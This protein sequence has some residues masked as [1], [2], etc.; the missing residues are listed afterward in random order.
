MPKYSYTVINQEGQKLTGTIEAD[1]EKAAQENLSK[2][3]FPILDITEISV[4]KL[5]ELSEQ[6]EKFEFQ[7]VDQNGKKVVGTIGASDKHA[8]FKRL[9]TEYHFAVEFLYQAAAS[10][11]AKEEEK[12]QGIVELYNEL[13]EEQSHMQAQQK[14]NEITENTEEKSQKV[15]KQVD[16]V[17]E[18]VSTLLSSF[19]DELKPDDKATIE[20]KSSRLTRL[21]TS[22]NIDYVKHLAEDLL[23]FMQNEEIYVPQE[24]ENKK[25]ELFRVDLKRVMNEIQREKLSITLRQD[26]LQKISDWRLKH[27]GGPEESKNIITRYTEVIFDFI[28]SLLSE[29]PEI[30]ALKEKI[31]MLDQQIWEYYKLFIKENTL[32][33]RAEIKESIRMLKEQKTDLKIE[34]ETTKKKLE[35][36][37]RL[38]EKDTTMEKVYSEITSITGWLFAI[39]F[40]IHVYNFYTT[41]RK[42]P[43]NGTLPLFGVAE[44]KNFLITML[45]LLLLHAFF[46]LRELFVLQKTAASLVL[47]PTFT[48]SI[49]LVLYNF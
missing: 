20:K 9:I 29:P 44:T 23:L 32:E 13:K 38:T 25:L 14:Q 22:K 6:T 42:L 45:I 43:V 19:K 33:G 15:I 10:L 41:T 7:A 3:G 8:A 49:L 2:L 35:E 36:E 28:E 47:I 40:S 12:K 34:L 37:V 46:R 30:T 16:T 48:I 31:E 21:K 4:E 27:G 26:I 5:E 39:Y 24:V 11:E 18:K 1:S 17:L